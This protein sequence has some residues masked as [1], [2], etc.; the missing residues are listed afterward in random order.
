[1]PSIALAS[2]NVLADAYVK[3]EY[4][5]HTPAPLLE[6]DG[7]RQRVLQRARELDV[8]VL[9]LQEVDD[10]LLQALRRE[11]GHR[12]FFVGKTAKP[13]GCAIV[14]RDHLR[15]KHEQEVR[16]V[17]GDGV[18]PDS[19]HVALLLILEHEGALFGVATTHLKW[20][21]A[22]TPPAEH[23]G[24]RQITQVLAAIEGLRSQCSAWI[25]CGD[26]NAT[27]DSEVVNAASAAGFVDLYRE[28]LSAFTSNANDKAK[29]ID[30][31]FHTPELRSRAGDVAAIDDVT[32]LPGET[33]PSDHLPIV[34]WFDR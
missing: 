4:F 1:M 34:G 7:R 8:D 13:D 24:L 26:F 32:P 23:T 21:A 25:V 28:S 29:R 30:Y 20:H 10:A 18:R 5:P 33:Q 2:W 17:D 27:A 31:L 9:C 19:G 14:V 12:V 22:Q 15:V 16:F 3:P 6:P 11:A